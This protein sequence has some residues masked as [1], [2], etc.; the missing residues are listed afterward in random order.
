LRNQFGAGADATQLAHANATRILPIVLTTHGTS[1][2]NN[3]YWPEMYLNQSIPD[4]KKRSPYGDTPSP[5]VF[6]NVSPTDPQLFSRIN[7]FADELLKGERSGKYTPIEVAQWIEDYANA[8]T[9]HLAQA[10]AS[11][12]NK[13][14][15][16]YRRMAIDLAMVAGLG[17]F[18]G[19]KFR[20]G[21]LYRIFEQSSDRSALVEALNYYKKARSFWAELANRAKDVYKP[22]ITIGENAVIRGHWL[23]RLPA[24]DEDIAFMANILEQNQ[25]S[26]SPQQDNVRLAI[27]EAI[28][29]PKRASAVCH[30]IQPEGFSAGQPLVIELS[31]EKTPASARLYYRHVNHGERYETAVMRLL[32]NLYRATIPATYTD[33]AYPV[34]YYFELKEGPDKAWLYPGFMPDL[35]NQPYF[36]LRRT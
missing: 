8:T 16:E 5:K 19:A 18:F 25:N 28:G 17:Q 4:P 29:R 27:Q 9:K 24:I 15:P 22:D 30:H 11:A 7:D 23:D 32:G 13:R 1:A 33:S 31:I 6:G 3:T 26:A 20:S 12:E 36:V 14:S 10:E 34:Q 35:A 21:V 2:G